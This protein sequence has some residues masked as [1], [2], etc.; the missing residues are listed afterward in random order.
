MRVVAIVCWGI[1]ATLGLSPEDPNNAAPR[2]IAIRLEYT[3][4]LE[5]SI[6]FGVEPA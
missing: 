2:V 6:T 3:W 4:L 5:G 1:G